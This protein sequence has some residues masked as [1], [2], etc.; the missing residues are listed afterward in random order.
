MIYKA[1]VEDNKDPK[2]MGRVRVRI[3]GL[4]SENK[5]DSSK[6][7]VDFIPTNLLP[8]ATPAYPITSST[9]SGDCDF[10]VPLCGS[11][12]LVDFFDSAKQCPFYFATIPVMFDNKPDSAIGFSDPA[13]VNPTADY[14]NESPINNLAKGMNSDM[15]A[16]LTGTNITEPSQSY[17]AEYPFNKVFA[18]GNLSIEMD[19]TDTKERVRIIGPE[20]SYIEMKSDGTIVIKSAQDKYILATGDCNLFGG[21]NINMTAKTGVINIVANTDTN[22]T[23]TGGNVDITASGVVNLKGGT[24]ALAGVVTGDCLCAYTG[25]NHAFKSATVLASI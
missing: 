18:F 20:K 1:V 25:N 9:I 7:D 15:G 10:A 14:T 2:M 24:G 11:I 17:A 12:V 22:I 3:A 19:N 4:H 16:A 23:T 8:W 21:T 6:K 13:S 5:T